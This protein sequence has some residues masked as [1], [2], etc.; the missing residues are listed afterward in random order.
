MATASCW[1]KS[2]GP[3]S[4]QPLPHACQVGWAMGKA[5]RVPGRGHF[6]TKAYYFEK[7]KAKLIR[8]YKKQSNIKPLRQIKAWY[9]QSGTERQQLAGRQEACW[10]Q[11]PS[12]P[13]SQVHFLVPPPGLLSED[14][15]ASIIAVSRPPGHGGWPWD[16]TFSW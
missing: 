9:R 13:L 8:V 3:S 11:W 15:F 5:P 16:P 10:T 14:E 6:F 12:L 4:G 7:D 1:N 2:R